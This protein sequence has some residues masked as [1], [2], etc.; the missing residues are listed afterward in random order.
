MARIL[1][2]AALLCTTSLQAHE[3]GH[4]HW[5]GDGYSD[6]VLCQSAGPAAVATAAAA[7]QLPASK[8]PALR[9][10]QG[11]AYTAPCMAFLARG[12]PA[13]S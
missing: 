6:C 5:L 2:L 10:H 12:P 11:V 9:L 7:P 8:A 1:V 4:Y 3:I 13:H